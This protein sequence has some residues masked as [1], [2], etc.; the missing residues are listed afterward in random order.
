MHLFMFHV[1]YLDK[2]Q[3]D[4]VYSTVNKESKT[5]NQPSQENDKAESSKGVAT[6]ASHSQALE[7]MNAHISRE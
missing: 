4:H 7:T 6:N 2:Q 5:S 1:D 3:F